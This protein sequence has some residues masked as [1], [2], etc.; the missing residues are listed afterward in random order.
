MSRASPSFKVGQ[1]CSFS[2]RDSHSF[3]AMLH[4][5]RLLASKPH[6]GVHSL[7]SFFLV[8]LAHVAAVQR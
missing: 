8:L 6:S 2:S 1:H 7:F 5:N 3:T 4:F